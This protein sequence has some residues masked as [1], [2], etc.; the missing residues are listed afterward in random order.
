M[1]KPTL[2]SIASAKARLS[3][4]LKKLEEEKP[5]LLNKKHQTPSIRYL[6][7]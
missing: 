6:I 2:D 4:E 5:S 1:S 7:C 3:E